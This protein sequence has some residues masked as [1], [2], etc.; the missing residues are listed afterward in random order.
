M[1][2]W[3]IYERLYDTGLILEYKYKNRYSEEVYRNEISGHDEGKS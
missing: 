2:K 1:L 3:L